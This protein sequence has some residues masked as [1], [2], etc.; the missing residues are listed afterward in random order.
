MANT[1]GALKKNSLARTTRTMARPTHFK[2]HLSKSKLS[3]EQPFFE[4]LLSNQSREIEIK[5]NKL[6]Q[7]EPPR[8]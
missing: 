7:E 5:E 2:G 1:H 4:E 6:C 8:S 3:V